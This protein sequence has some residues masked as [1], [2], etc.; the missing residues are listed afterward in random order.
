M[1]DR[2]TGAYARP[3]EAFTAAEQVAKVDATANPALKARFGVE[4]FPTF[5]SFRKGMLVT[6]G[7]SFSEKPIAGSIVKFVTRQ[8][9]AP[10]VAPTD[11]AL[12]ALEKKHAAGVL[13]VAFL[14]SAGGGKAAS[15]D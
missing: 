11:D 3:Y 15:T 2:A 14:A 7:A 1:I 4:S 9:A 6:E 10:V 8:A 5:F 13:I 12:L